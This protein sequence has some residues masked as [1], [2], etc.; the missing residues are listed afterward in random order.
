ML[1]AHGGAIVPPVA[2]TPPT[3]ASW[4]APGHWVIDGTPPSYAAPIPYQLNEA[5]RDTDRVI[6]ALARTPPL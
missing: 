4:S 5:V 2:R 1:A 6:G 3:V